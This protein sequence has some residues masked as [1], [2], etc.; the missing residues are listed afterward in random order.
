MAQAISAQTAISG[1]S[2]APRAMS[3]AP[4][5][6]N[7]AVR[8]RSFARPRDKTIDPTPISPAELRFGAK[9]RDRSHVDLSV[10]LFGQAHTCPVV[11]AP[12]DLAGM[13]AR[14][15]DVRAA[16][17]AQVAGLNPCIRSPAK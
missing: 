8:A 9:M 3:I 13:N 16:G 2:P 5:G 6:L 15:G 7:G 10:T 11:F 12:T 1:K 4:V 14:L 17:V